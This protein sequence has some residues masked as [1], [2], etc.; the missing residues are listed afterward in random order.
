MGL[1]SLDGGKSF[2]PHKKNPIFTNDY[3]NF[4]ENEHMGGNFELIK[5]D[6]IDYII[7]QGKSSY[8]DSKYNILLREREKT[9]K[10]KF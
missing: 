9:T 5:T 1:I 3:S 7:Y 6:S 4:Y 10:S 8:I 2:T